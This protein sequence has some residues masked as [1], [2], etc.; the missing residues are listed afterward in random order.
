MHDE[1]F[2]QIEW[3]DQKIFQN[4]KKND[5]QDENQR[6]REII[7]RNTAWSDKEHATDLLRNDIHVFMKNQKFIIAF[8]LE[9][10]KRDD[11][12]WQYDFVQYTNDQDT[13]TRRER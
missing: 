2:D 4:L 8:S 13:F 5:R 1:W 7:Q 11:H 6:H 12:E 9:L 3:R 10:I